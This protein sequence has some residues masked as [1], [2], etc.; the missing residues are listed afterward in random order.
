MCFVV[1]CV[2]EDHATSASSSFLQFVKRVFFT[3][4]YSS[5]SYLHKPLLLYPHEDM[6]G[7]SIVMQYLKFMGFG[8]SS[9]IY[10]GLFNKFEERPTPNLSTSLSRIKGKEKDYLFSNT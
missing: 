5:S 8:C 1:S 9:N 6:Y 2:C 3:F 4:S 7:V 10:H